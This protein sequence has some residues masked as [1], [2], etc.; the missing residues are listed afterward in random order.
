MEEC[1]KGK[2]RCLE[3]MKEY[4]QVDVLAF[5]QRCILETQSVG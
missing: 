3:E 1:L 4:N 2:C 5:F